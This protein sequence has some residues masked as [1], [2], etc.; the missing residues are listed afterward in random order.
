MKAEFTPV[1]PFSEDFQKHWDFWKQYKKEEHSFSYRSAMSE[2]AGLNELVDL[3]DGDEKEAIRIIN[4]SM[5]NGWKG[6]FRIHKPK[7]DGKSTKKKAAG[8][9]DADALKAV[10]IKRNGT[11]G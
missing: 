8:G 4:K 6:L 7:E 2:Q 11:E 5:S 10:Y 1:N 3:S 9:V